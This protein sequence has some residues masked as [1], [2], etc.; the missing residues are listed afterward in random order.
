M[1]TTC[2][3][4]EV[5]KNNKSICPCR[6]AWLSVTLLTNTRREFA[7]PFGT[8]TAFDKNDVTHVSQEAASHSERFVL[9][10]LQLAQ[11]V[12]PVEVVELF[13]IPKDDPPLAPEV[14]GHV[15]PLQFGEVVLSNVTQSLHVLPLCG[16][17]LLHDPWQFPVQTVEELKSH[18]DKIQGPKVPKKSHTT[19]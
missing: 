11:E 16:Q 15:C 4:L 14:L 6:S 5:Y 1:S 18:I 12:M 3:S 13:Q 9:T 17:Q 8:I 19:I 2:C 7:V 10:A